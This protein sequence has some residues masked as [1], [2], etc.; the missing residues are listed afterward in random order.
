MMA[1]DGRIDLPTTGEVNGDGSEAHYCTVDEPFAGAGTG[2]VE[3]LENGRIVTRFNQ[4]CIDFSQRV[5]GD[6]YRIEAVIAQIVQTLGLA[7]ASDLQPDIQFVSKLFLK[8]S[9][10]MLGSTPQGTEIF[11]SPPIYLGRGCGP[12]NYTPKSPG[13]ALTVGGREALLRADPI[14]LL[15]FSW[16]YGVPCN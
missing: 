12:Q 11:R 16:R 6:T 15:S 10:Q 13:F 3:L 4:I 2:E 14:G 5:D 1:G 9:V 7:K 8:G